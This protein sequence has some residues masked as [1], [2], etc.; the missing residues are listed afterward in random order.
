MYFHNFQDA[1]SSASCG[2]NKPCI[3]L[4]FKDYS[5]KVVHCLI[6]HSATDLICFHMCFPSL[7]KCTYTILQ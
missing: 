4:G 2:V 1:L 6:I 5:G 7:K 3:S